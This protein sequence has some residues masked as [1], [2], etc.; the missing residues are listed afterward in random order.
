MNITDYEKIATIVWVA[1]DGTFGKIIK[2]DRNATGWDCRVELALGPTVLVRCGTSGWQVQ[3]KGFIGQ[4]VD[5]LE[6]AARLALE[7]GRD[8]DA[9]RN[10]KMR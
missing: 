5:R 6:E 9:T 2:L 10:Y 1:Q 7:A 4:D 8:I 3:F